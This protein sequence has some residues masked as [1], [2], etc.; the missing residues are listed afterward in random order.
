MG[1]VVRVMP[2][3][4]FTPGEGHPVP[5]DRE[6]GGPQ[7]FSGLK[8]LEEKSFASAEDRTPVALSSSL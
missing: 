8:R 3:S 5:L 2:Q 6:L 4:R 7:S 1:W